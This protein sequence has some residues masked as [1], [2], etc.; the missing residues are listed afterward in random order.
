MM[1][2][3]IAQLVLLVQRVNTTSATS[4]WWASLCAIPRIV[5]ILNQSVKIIKYSEFYELI[6]ENSS[7]TIQ[8]YS[9]HSRAIIVSGL[10]DT[11]KG[12]IWIVLTLPAKDP[13]DLTTS[14]VLWHTEA[15]LA[16]DDGICIPLT[17]HVGHFKLLGSA[18]ELMSLQGKNMR[19]EG[20]M[21]VPCHSGWSGSAYVKLW[22]HEGLSYYG[23]R[24]SMAHTG[25][26]QAIR[27]FSWLR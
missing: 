14:I 15:I 25:Q 13:V 19:R 21:Y 26:I 12:T 16:W 22:V 1:N 11:P 17:W 2:D 20:C 27:T 24:I 18:W 5:T 10:W 7:I 23:H 6:W 4:Y 9:L 3:I 8:K